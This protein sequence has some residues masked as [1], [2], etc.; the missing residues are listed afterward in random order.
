[1]L[2]NNI[3]CTNCYLNISFLLAILLING[4]VLRYA[5]DYFAKVS[6][7]IGF[8]HWTNCFY[9]D[10]QVLVVFPAVVF[11]ATWI[12]L[13]PVVYPQDILVCKLLNNLSQPV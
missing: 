3:Y 8:I 7:L 4:G 10:S 13:F 9:I 11:R 6:L 1:M 2:T 12:R 5:T